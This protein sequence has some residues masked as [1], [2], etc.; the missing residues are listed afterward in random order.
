MKGKMAKI[1]KRGIAAFLVLVLLSSDVCVVPAAE[2]SL[3]QVITQTV[4]VQD[5]LYER[6]FQIT[7]GGTGIYEDVLL[8]RYGE[9]ASDVM[10][11]IPVAMYLNGTEEYLSLSTSAEKGEVVS[12][13]TK[14]TRDGAEQFVLIKDADWTQ[15]NLSYYIYHPKSGYYMGLNQNN[16]LY[17]Y[18][19]EKPNQTF[20]FKKTG[21]SDV[22]LLTTL[23]GYSQLSEANQKRVLDIYGGIGARS[24][25]REGG[26]DTDKTIERAL[27]DAAV[28][29][30]FKNLLNF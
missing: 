7:S 19:K 8:L 2:S 22:G 13:N 18:G 12:C 16:K 1:L 23:D 20:V 26:W 25:F 30:S 17:A 9:E 29:I 24:L 28:D 10:N 11:Y 27:H 5:L 15:E 6:K 14:L 4:N 3:E 21:Y